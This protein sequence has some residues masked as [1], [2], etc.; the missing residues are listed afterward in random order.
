M[1]LLMDRM[2]LIDRIAVRLR[3]FENCYNKTQTVKQTVKEVC[4][5]ENE[6]ESF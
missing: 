6:Q 5:H 1:I 4:G 3:Q 2:N